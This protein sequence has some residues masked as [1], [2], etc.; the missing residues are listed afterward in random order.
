MVHANNGSS[1]SCP[2]LVLDA[3]LRIGTVPLNWSSLLLRGPDDWQRH[4]GE[5]GGGGS[6]WVKRPETPGMQSLSILSP[7]VKLSLALPVLPHWVL[8]QVQ[9]SFLVV[10]LFSSESL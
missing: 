8:S 10:F 9:T 6:S 3:R 4:W 5:A 7:P 1:D 2:K